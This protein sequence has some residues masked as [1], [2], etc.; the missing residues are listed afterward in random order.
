MNGLAYFIIGLEILAVV[1]FIVLL[2][3]LIISRWGRGKNENFEKRD[4]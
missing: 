1:I 4:N 3:H 2:I